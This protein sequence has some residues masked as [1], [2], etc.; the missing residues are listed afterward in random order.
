MGKRLKQ[1]KPKSLIEIDNRKLIDIQLNEL[2]LA[3]IKAEDIY[4]V[5][6]YKSE[7]FS[8]Y[9][10]NKILN[11]DFETTNQVYSISCASNLSDEK[12]VVV[13]YGDI[14]FENTLISKLYKQNYNFVIPTFN[15]FKKLWQDRGDYDFNDLESFSINKKGE[16]LDIGNIVEDIDQV[17]GQFMGIVY[18]DNYWFKRFLELYES[19][20]LLHKK[21]FLTLQTTNFLN[22]L[23]KNDV[24]IQSLKYD[25][26][27]MELDNQKDLDLIRKTLPF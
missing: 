17:Q 14:I 11:Q 1:E 26:Y 13:I 20:K 19:Y 3:G 25:G 10:L 16:I 24:H 18:F 6:G 7:L 5:T 2:Q 12:E 27:F 15:D 23:I 4:V 8:E 9:K 21:K 22:Y